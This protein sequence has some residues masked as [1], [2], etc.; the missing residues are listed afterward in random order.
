[1]PYTTIIDPADLHA[2]LDDPDWAIVDARF[3]LH[4]PARG[5]HD[6]E[7]AHIPGAVYAH[8]DDDLSGD[9]VPGV[10]GRHP[11]PDPSAFSEKLSAWGIADGVQVVVYDDIG[12]GIAARLWWMLRWLGHDAVAVLDGGFPAWQAA[13][14]PTRSGEESRPSRSFKP[15]PH[16]EM[17]AEV[18]EV[19]TLRNDEAC[20]LLDARAGARYRGALEPIDPVAG[21]IP[22]AV[23]APYGG[24]L[25]DDQRFLS[26]QQLRERFATVLEDVPPEQTV[27]YCG[28][29]VTAA[30]DIL[31]MTHAGLT[32]AR[33]YPGSWSHW[34]TDADRPVAV[35]EDE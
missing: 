35:V 33:L 29:G 16:P 7:A 2:H 20:R 34:I 27:V 26:P 17:V 22:G 28:S 10:T 30:H 18:E 3:S 31:A 25:D 12:G 21:H 13:G 23:S 8:L 4:E 6:Y 15:Q 1:M 5:R 9:I 11:L 14:Y 24:N 32:G 19:E